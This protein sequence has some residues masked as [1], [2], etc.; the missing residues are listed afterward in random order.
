MGLSHSPPAG[1][2]RAYDPRLAR[3]LLRYLKPYRRQLLVA[4]LMM[5][6]ASLTSLAAPYLIKVAIDRYILVEPRL[7]GLILVGVLYLAVQGFNWF[8]S[9]WQQY[10]MALMGQRAVYDLRRDLFEHLQRLSLPFFERQPAGVIISRVTNDIMALR[11][12]LSSGIIHIVGDLLTLVGIVAIMLAMNTRLTLYLFLFLP[13]V[14]LLASV[15]SRRIRDSYRLVRQRVAEINAALQEGISGVRISQS[16]VREGVNADQFAQVNEANLQANMQAVSLFSL[17]MPL[18]EIVGAVGTAMVIWVGGG[19]IMGRPGPVHLAG[20]QF[21]VGELVAFLAY[22]GRFYQPIRDLSQ[23]Y[24]TLLSATAACEKVFGILD[25]KPE[26]R[27]PARPM[28]PRRVMGRLTVSGVWFGYEADAPVLQGIDLQIDPGRRV[29]LV[30]RTGAGKT[31]LAHLVARFYD[32]WQGSVQLDGIDLRHLAPAVL[33]RNIA[34]VL[35]DPILFRGTVASNLRYGRPTADDEELWRT[36]RQLG[37]EDWLRSLP[38]GLE[39]AVE[40]R[41][42]NFSAGQRQ[43]LALARALVCDPRVLVLDEA[44]ANVDIVTERLIVRTMRAALASRTALII[45]HRLNTVRDADAIVVLADGKVCQAGSHGEL[46]ARPGL[47][48]ELC[49]QQFARDSHALR[50][51][52]SGG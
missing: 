35:Q 51:A 2:V 6:G 16:F 14:I 24:N 5:V 3:R 36:A 32:P 17:F 10:L 38:Q 28:I 33:R 47:Y 46:V 22:L 15:F 34:L 31:T 44:T 21:S 7:D 39:T 43:L 8:F 52:D 19:L 26:V 25:T 18:V 29:A 48:R 9:Y 42:G 37:I 40:E 45:A 23:V 20:G 4:C 41:G 30:G 49:R 12:M 27:P 13:T 1:A 11:E 50:G